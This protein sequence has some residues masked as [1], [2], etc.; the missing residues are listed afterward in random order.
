MTLQAFLPSRYSGSGW[1]NLFLMREC[2]IACQR[3]EQ[4]SSDDGW[5]ACCRLSDQIGGI[6]LGQISSGRSDKPGLFGLDWWL[7]WGGP[8]RLRAG[9]RGAD[10]RRCRENPEDEWSPWESMRAQRCLG[11]SPVGVGTPSIGLALHELPG[12]AD[13]LP[14]LESS[15]AGNGQPGAASSKT[16]QNCNLLSHCLNCFLPCLPTAWVQA[17]HP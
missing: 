12:L 8:G 16:E 13:C 4:P 6:E 7:R 5:L 9:G 3:P 14:R 11:C 17:L 10:E 15:L 1:G 2:S